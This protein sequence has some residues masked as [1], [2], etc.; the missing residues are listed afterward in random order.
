MKEGK[1]DE[2][3]PRGLKSRAGVNFNEPQYELPF[4]GRLRVAVVRGRLDKTG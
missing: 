4:R 1:E 2:K 3:R